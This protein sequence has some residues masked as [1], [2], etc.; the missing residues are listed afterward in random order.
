VR[1]REHTFWELYGWRVLAVSLLIVLET[2]LIAGLLIQRTRRRRAEAQVREGEQAMRLAAS[3]AQLALW[4][5]DIVHDEIWFAELTPALSGLGATPH[6][7]LDRFVQLVHADDRAAVRRAIARALQGDG[8]YE[9][10]YRATADDGRIHWFAGSGRVEFEAG[11]P[12]RLRGV[13]LDITRRKNAELEAQRQ[14]AEFTHL[15]RV[16][17]LGELSGSLA[18]E[19]NQPLTA[20]LSNAQAARMFIAR[21]PVDLVE[22]GEILEDIVV[23]DKRAGEIIL[24]LRK[25]LV[26]EAVT[27][28]PV[29]INDVV[30]EVLK[31]M[32]SDLVNRGVVV[33]VQLA[34]DAP[35]V[36]GDRIQLQQVLLNLLINACDAMEGNVA[37]E[38][39]VAVRTEAIEHGVRVSVE[40]RGCGVP[41][42]Q[43]AAIFAPFFTTK[44]QGLGL[45]LAVCQSII[46][47]HGGVIRA[48]NNAARGAVF[49]F[50]LGA[51]ARDV[52]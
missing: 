35:E 50:E 37:A 45:G 36:V 46:A 51:G 31:L 21:E 4:T 30:Q 28:E 20:I 23:N 7:N 34:S 17:M 39:V 13:T 2:A 44:K 25:M 43:V 3:A 49:T 9:S 15:S 19:L 33:N 18:H 8:V 48:A 41:D 16:T 29:A 1:H 26:K 38:R 22:L 42:D 11:K 5:W 47:A 14:R 52:A 24:R 40:D 32:H 10:E 6:P 12:R 27:H